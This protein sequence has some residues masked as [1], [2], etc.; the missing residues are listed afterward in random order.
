MKLLVVLSCY[1]QW[2]RAGAF[3]HSSS[4]YV[5]Q[6]VCVCRSV[7]RKLQVLEVL[8]GFP[9]QQGTSR[10]ENRPNLSTWKP[11]GVTF[12]FSWCS[13]QPCNLLFLAGQFRICGLV[14]PGNQKL[15]Q[16]EE[17]SLLTC[18][19]SHLILA[20]HSQ[21]PPLFEVELFRAE[22]ALA[23]DGDPF[24]CPPNP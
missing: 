13:E 2:P 12:I 20:W 21:L 5:C 1:W 16:T 8:I 6:Y 4:H 9:S 14:V 22:S 7:I 10:K 19:P 24:G 15:R 23:P 3:W 17:V 11:C 18:F